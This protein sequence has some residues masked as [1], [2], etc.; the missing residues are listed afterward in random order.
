MHQFYTRTDRDGQLQESHVTIDDNEL[1][2]LIG[3]HI[4]PDGFRLERWERT[5]GGFIWEFVRAE[6]K[7]RE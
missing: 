2:A 3:S 4:A 1:M 7:T 5:L 6:G